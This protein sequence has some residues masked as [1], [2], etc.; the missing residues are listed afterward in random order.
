MVL[1]ANVHGSASRVPE[2][3]V[4]DDFLVLGMGARLAIHLS[5]PA[6]F[7]LRIGGQL[8]AH[9]L[10]F[11]LTQGGSRLFRSPAVSATLGPAIVRVF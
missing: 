11:T 6:D 8:L 4:S 1:V 5:L 2:G 10:P 9:P 7:A 3:S